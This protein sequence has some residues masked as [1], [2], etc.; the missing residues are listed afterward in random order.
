[1]KIEAFLP[2]PLLCPAFSK[3]A[4]QKKVFH[5]NYSM[6]DLPARITCFHASYF[7]FFCWPLSFLQI[8]A[9]H[10]ETHS[11]PS[12]DALF[13][14]D[15]KIWPS[16]FMNLEFVYRKDPV[17]VRDLGAEEQWLILWGFLYR[18]LHLY[19]QVRG[20]K[21]ASFYDS[22]GSWKDERD[23]I[24]VWG[25]SRGWNRRRTGRKSK[26]VDRKAWV[27]GGLLPFPWGGHPWPKS[28]ALPGARGL[29]SWLMWG[30][31]TPHKVPSSFLGGTL[32]THPC[33]PWTPSSVGVPVHC[34]S[35]NVPKPTTATQW[36]WRQISKHSNDNR[37]TDTL[38]YQLTG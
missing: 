8:F 18:C 6:C 19:S 30:L 38:P 33:A 14:L 34:F 4:E 32:G 29:G 26:R 36:Q 22:S 21:G 16:V 3:E 10:L 5:E 15:R 1:M 9:L 2:S 37:V 20:G 27:G 35:G 25:E 31:P 17:W 23:V 13:E 12:L 24:T 28:Q 11:T 7:F